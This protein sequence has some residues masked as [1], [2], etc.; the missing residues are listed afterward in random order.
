MEVETKRSDRLTFVLIILRMAEIVRL[1]LYQP[2]LIVECR[3]PEQAMAEHIGSGIET[4][5]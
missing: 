2:R 1:L 4:S 3:W 5:K